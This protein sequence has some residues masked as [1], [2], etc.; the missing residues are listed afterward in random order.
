MKEEALALIKDV[1]GFLERPED[2]GLLTKENIE[3]VLR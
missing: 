3:S 1:Q 2:A